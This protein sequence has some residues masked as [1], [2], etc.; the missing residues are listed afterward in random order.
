[1]SEVPF[2]ASP[3]EVTHSSQEQQ[4]DALV[5][6]A[7]A[8]DHYEGVSE[9]CSRPTPEQNPKTPVDL[10]ESL[11]R[12]AALGALLDGTDRRTPA[13][14]KEYDTSPVNPLLDPEWFIADEG[15][16]VDLHTLVAQIESN[17][18]SGLEER[19]ARIDAIVQAYKGHPALAKAKDSLLKT[20]RSAHPS[21]TP[22]SYRR[23]SKGEEVELFTHI[24][25]GV[26]ACQ[27]LDTPS[28]A[29]DELFTKLAVAHSMI[30]LANVHLVAH[31][32]IA[33]S[34][35]LKYV[36]KS[37]IKA[38]YEGLNHAIGSRDTVD[39]TRFDRQAER[40]IGEAMITYANAHPITY[41]HSGDKINPPRKDATPSSKPGNKKNIPKESPADLDA[42]IRSALSRDS[43]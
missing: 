38:G 16:T 25:T 41:A 4:R 39:E 22:F 30:F 10:A 29:M 34:K 14:I 31:M 5:A 23:L 26:L 6:A 19:H 3:G 40:A 43:D 42:R 2:S 20:P 7:K 36:R 8:L 1:M 18:E 32:S 28:K 15:F 37:L 12:L 33:Y 11:V 9:D 21:H 35:R 13:Q 27:S 17:K 24:D